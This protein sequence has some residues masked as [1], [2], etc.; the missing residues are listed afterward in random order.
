MIW[1]RA[2]SRRVYW[3]AVPLAA[4]VGLTWWLSQD[5]ASAAIKPAQATS[6]GA[7]PPPSSRQDIAEPRHRQHARQ[8]N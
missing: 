2:R 6:L 7:L 4:L 5:E 3:L 8:Q 1:R